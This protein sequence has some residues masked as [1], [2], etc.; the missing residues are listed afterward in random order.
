[1]VAA[2][3]R[4]SS[5]LLGSRK[6]ERTAYGRRDRNYSD[7]DCAY[8]ARAHTSSLQAEAT[9]RD[10]EEAANQLEAAPTVVPEGRHLCCRK[11]DSGSQPL[12]ELYSDAADSTTAGRLGQ[13]E[14][15]GLMKHTHSAEVG[16]VRWRDLV[17]VYPAHSHSAGEALV[18]FVRV[19]TADLVT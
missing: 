2:Q 12:A 9:V 5:C 11:A 1:M 14:A 10:V 18:S 3:K 6:L 19:A 13:A 17:Q 7:L 16:L 4:C 8:Q 15:A